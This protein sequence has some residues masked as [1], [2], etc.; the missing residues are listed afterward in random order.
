[1]RYHLVARWSVIGSML[2]VTSASEISEI[3][4]YNVLGELIGSCTPGACEAIMT[5][6][7]RGLG[8]VVVAAGGIV[9]TYKI[10]R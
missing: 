1:M 8:I 6:N 2:S 7:A 10:V 9:Q 5:V 4:V 3:R